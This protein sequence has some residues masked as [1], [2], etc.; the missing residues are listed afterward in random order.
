MVGLNVI[1]DLF[2]DPSNLKLREKASIPEGVSRA[3]NH[4][5]GFEYILLAN[6]LAQMDL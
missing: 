4:I 3:T 6:L 5:G 1:P 2:W